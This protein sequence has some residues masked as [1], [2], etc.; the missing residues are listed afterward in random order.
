MISSKIF[1][2]A[3][4]RASPSFT[5]TS[6]GSSRHAKPNS[7]DGTGWRTCQRSQHCSMFLSHPRFL[8]SVSRTSNAIESSHR[9]SDS[10]DYQHYHPPLHQLTSS[11]P[12][13][14]PIP[15]D[16]ARSRL[17]LASYLSSTTSSSTW[18]CTFPN[19]YLSYSRD[20]VDAIVSWTRHRQCVVILLQMSPMA[21][22][23]P[24]LG[25]AAFSCPE[26]VIHNHHPL[27]AL[28]SFLYHLSCRI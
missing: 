2:R 4:N 21:M 16:S 25:W 18:V 24:G 26:I 15:S 20:Y 1:E 27:S 3:V 13:V 28:P 23:Q 10:S 6:F 12:S 8:I 19:R 9:V 14:V 11:D 5:F 17:I 7:D 22:L